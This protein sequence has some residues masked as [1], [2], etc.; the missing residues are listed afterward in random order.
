MT[1]DG[2]AVRTDHLTRRF[3]PILAV[4]HL[5]FQ[6][7]RGE[8]F[9]ILGPNGSGKSTTMRMLCGLVEPTEGRAEVLGLDPAT[10]P[11]QV[12]ER[13]GYL[14]Q[15]FGLYHDLTVQENLEFYAEIYGLPS[16]EWRD[17]FSKLLADAGLTGRERHLSGTLSGGLR[18]RLAFICT[19]LHRP[20]LLLLDEPTVGLDPTSRRLMWDLIYQQAGAGTAVIVSTHYMDEAERCQTL[21]F[22]QSGRMAALGSPAEIKA[23]PFPGA[24]ARLTTPTPGR[25]LLE[26]ETYP[27]VREAG[28]Y[29]GDV[30]I[31]LHDAAQAAAVVAHLRQRGFEAGDPVPVPPTLEDLFVGLTGERAR[32]PEPADA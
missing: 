5:D 24:I 30:H 14:A 2:L 19:L 21:M 17:K 12:K 31:W 6:V 4:D 11:Q 9:G 26:V 29:G 20:Q 27:E 22:L 18:Q 3:G 23:L 7:E 25:L 1:G 28:L 10:Q 16:T 32:R 15:Q 8:V 13:V